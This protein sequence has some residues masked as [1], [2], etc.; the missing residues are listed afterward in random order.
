MPP[1]GPSRP[2]G[3]QG[4]HTGQGLQVRGYR[5]GATGQWFQ[6]TGYRS[7]ATD[8]WLQGRG[9]SSE[10][11]GQGLQFRGHSS[12]ATG[13]GLQFR[14]YISGATGQGLVEGGSDAACKSFAAHRRSPSACSEKTGGP[15]SARAEVVRDER[16]AAARADGVAQHD[17]ARQD[18]EAG[19]LGAGLPRLLSR[20]RV[21][22]RECARMRARTCARGRA[23]ACVCECVCACV[24]VCARVS[25]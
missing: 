13:Q 17:D 24:C 6:V 14:G 23:R 12:G 11:T 8:R 19:L 18:G 20:H 21:T 7:V 5:S 3:A 16:V 25:V 15:R 1:A 10:A 9:H 2:I 4:L 22:T